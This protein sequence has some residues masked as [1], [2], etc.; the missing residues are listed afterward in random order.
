M[1]K[2]QIDLPI[3]SMTNK[4]SVAAHTRLKHLAEK[5]GFL[6]QD[7]LSA[8]LLHMPE[9]ELVRI[10]TEHKEALEEMPA[11]AKAVLKNLDSLTKADREAL[12]K[13]L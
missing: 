8:C 6:I 7:V 9:D 4:V 10:L 5:H 2:L 11:A 1:K 12:K 13:L 3:Q